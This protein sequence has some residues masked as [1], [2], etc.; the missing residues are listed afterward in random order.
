MLTT[1]PSD[2]VYLKGF[3][4]NVTE[5][6]VN[7]RISTM[8]ELDSVRESLNLDFEM[9]SLR[10]VFHFLK[11]LMVKHEEVTIEMHKDLLPPSF[12]GTYLVVK[13]RLNKFREQSK[14]DWIT[15]IF[16]KNPWMTFRAGYHLP[17]VS[18]VSR[19]TD[20]LQTS[21]I[22]VVETDE[23]PK[24]YRDQLA[25]F[26]WKLNRLGHKVEIVKVG[27]EIHIIKVEK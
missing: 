7:I 16:R 9:C 19:L 20:A 5:N 8:E 17:T 21:K 2:K 6:Y 27:N 11:A 4:L 26:R 3:R 14:V 12:W 1:P 22:V 24:G 13:A 15:N 25:S 18:F 10:T 23:M